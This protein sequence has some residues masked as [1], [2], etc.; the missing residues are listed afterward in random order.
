MCRSGSGF[1]GSRFRGCLKLRQIIKAALD[2][3][4]ARIPLR[5][6]SQGTVKRC[7][8]APVATCDGGNVGPCGFRRGAPVARSPRRKQYGRNTKDPRRLFASKSAGP[9]RTG[10]RFKRFR[11]VSDGF[12][13]NHGKVRKTPRRFGCGRHRHGV[14]PGPCGHNFRHPF[15]RAAAEYFPGAAVGGCRREKK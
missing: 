9:V 8:A 6:C 11:K 3:R 13:R 5:R 7:E 4:N 15:R 2:H 12:Q 1:A 10:L 14:T